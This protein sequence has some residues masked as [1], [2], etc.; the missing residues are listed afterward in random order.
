MTNVYDCGPINIQQGNS[1][2]INVEFLSSRGVLTVP[3]S[4]NAEI[5][6]LNLSLASVTETVALSETNDF[7]TGVW[8]S[9]SASLGIAIYVITASGST[10]PQATGQLRIIERQSTF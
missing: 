2:R 3:A 5:T 8:S 1:A 7:F 6:Y 10:T 4:A 9:T